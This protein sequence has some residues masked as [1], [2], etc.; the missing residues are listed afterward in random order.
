MSPQFPNAAGYRWRMNLSPYVGRGRSCQFV[1]VEINKISVVKM[2]LEQGWHWYEFDV[3]NG[4]IQ[5]GNNHVRFLFNYSSAPKTH[6]ISGDA[7]RLSVAFDVLDA[8]PQ[9]L[10]ADNHRFARDP[11]N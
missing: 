1:E 3:P 9:N 6:G 8:T 5:S 11:A 10:T 2:L 4:V 7:R